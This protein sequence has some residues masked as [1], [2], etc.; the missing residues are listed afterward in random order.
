MPFRADEEMKKGRERAYARLL[1]P[2]VETAERDRSR[3]VLDGLIDRWGPVVET[4][5]HWHPFVINHKERNPVST[6]G[7][8]CGYQGLDHTMFLAHAIITCPYTEGKDIYQSIEELAR[9]PKL[10]GIADL[11]VEEVEAQ[12]YHPKAKPILITCK[13]AEPL[14]NDK[15]IPT[16]LAVPLLLEQEIPSWRWA[17]VAETWETMAPYILGR[18]CGSRSSLFLGQETGQRLKELWNLL[19]KTGMFGPIYVGSRR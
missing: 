2:S 13:W 15:T 14:N 19:I 16:E 6:P 8:A 3:D 11:E 5:P 4:Y 7:S 10:D 17:Q 18:P 12:L 9:N 1:G